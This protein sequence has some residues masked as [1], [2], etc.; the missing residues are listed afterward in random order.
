[1]KAGTCRLAFEVMDGR[2][3]PSTVA[4]GDIEFYRGPVGRRP[5]GLCVHGA[6]PS[7]STMPAT[8][9]RRRTRRATEMIRIP[10]HFDCLGR[11]GDQLERLRSEM[12]LRFGERDALVRQ[13]SEIDPYLLLGQTAFASGAEHL[14]DQVHQPVAVLQHHVVELPPFRLVDRCAARLPN[15]LAHL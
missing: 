12:A 4:Y 15:E 11:T 5:A 1:M 7:P 14:V 9:E 8:T 6:D 10:H 3:V 2:D 13:R